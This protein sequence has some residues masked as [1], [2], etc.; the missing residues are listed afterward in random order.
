MNLGAIIK[1][2]I[3]NDVNLVRTHL[4]L[5]PYRYTKESVPATYVIED[6]LK[7]HQLRTRLVNVYPERL[8]RIGE[9]F[10]YYTTFLLLVISPTLLQTTENDIGIPST[11]FNNAGLRTNSERAVIKALI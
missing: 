11:W 10:Q 7:T 6:F 9:I 2:Q 8:Q 3:Y 5:F 4:P 1:D